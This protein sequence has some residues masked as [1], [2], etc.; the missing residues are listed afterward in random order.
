VLVAFTDALGGGAPGEVTNS[1][2][3]TVMKRAK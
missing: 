3:G 2:A 1:V